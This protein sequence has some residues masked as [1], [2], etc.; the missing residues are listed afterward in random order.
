MYKPDCGII[1]IIAVHDAALRL[2][3]GIVQVVQVALREDNIFAT[4]NARKEQICWVW[5]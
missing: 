3:A 4:R 5:C 1:T 2:K